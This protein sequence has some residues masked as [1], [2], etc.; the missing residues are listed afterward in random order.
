[1]FIRQKKVR[2]HVYLQLVENCW[3]EGATRQ[4]TVAS[5]GRL[6]R[7]QESGPA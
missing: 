3:E 2:P 7:L 1:M 4:R 5:L 6:D